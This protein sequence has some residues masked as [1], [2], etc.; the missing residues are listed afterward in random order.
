MIL[1]RYQSSFSIDADYYCVVSKEFNL[2]KKGI[3]L[4]TLVQILLEEN[5]QSKEANG[6]MF[7]FR[8]YRK[9]VDLL[10]VYENVL[11]QV[12]GGGGRIK[13]GEGRARHY[14]GI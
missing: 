2:D 1:D 11:Q 12:G 8:E 14:Q 9:E 4:S 13:E 10:E 5:V 7:N 3:F 6:E